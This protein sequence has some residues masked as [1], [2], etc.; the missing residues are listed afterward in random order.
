MKYKKKSTE[1]IILELHSLI[2]LKETYKASEYER[3]LKA[4]LKEVD[5][6]LLLNKKQESNN[7]EQYL[8]LL[9]G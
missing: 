6:Q 7:L 8:K 2:S 1:A 5:N 4:L 3:K 9:I